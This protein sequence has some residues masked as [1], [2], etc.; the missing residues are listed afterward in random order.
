MKL[1]LILVLSLSSIAGSAF[2]GTPDQDPVVQVLRDKFAKAEPMELGD[3]QIGK[4]WVCKQFSALRNNFTMQ[5]PERM[6]S[7]SEFDGTLS[8]DLTDIRTYVFNEASGLVG[9]SS[10]GVTFCTIR[11]GQRFDLLFECTISLKEGDTPSISDSSRVAS[12]YG[13]CPAEKL[14]VLT[15]R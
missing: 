11:K 10:D 9:R 6:F 7:F 14:Q 1:F 4:A 15:G 2:A 13:M 5:G 12:A 8:N 3:L